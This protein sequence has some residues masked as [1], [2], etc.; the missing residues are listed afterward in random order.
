MAYLGDTYNR[1]FPE[2]EMQG[3]PDARNLGPAGECH[4]WDKG[5]GPNTVSVEYG[6]F[7]SPDDY[8]GGG[9]VSG[10]PTCQD[11]NDMRTRPRTEKRHQKHG[12]RLIQQ[13]KQELL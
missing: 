7:E 3:V 10:L 1:P 9:L 11:R 12:R 13:H 4:V 8:S 6:S 5:T 2:G